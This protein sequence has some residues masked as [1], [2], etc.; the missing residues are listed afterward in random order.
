VGTVAALFDTT[1][2]ILLL[3]RKHPPET[4][5]LIRAAKS[6]IERGSALLPA[7]AVTELVLGERDSAGAERLSSVLAK[8]P[9]AVLPAEAARDAGAM[10]SFLRAEGAPIPVPD[11][12]IAA[13]AVWLGLPLLTW[14]GDYARSR[15]RALAGRSSHRGAER[16]RTLVLHPASRGA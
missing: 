10:G 1:V 12:L 8:I 2:G 16:W 4:V 3:R 5:P 13:T 7:M 9:T 15:E 14:D 11:L 6:E